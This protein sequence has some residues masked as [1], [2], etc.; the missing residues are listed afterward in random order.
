M[1]SP[2]INDPIA[3]DADGGI[4]GQPLDHAIFH[5]AFWADDEES[6]GLMD[7]IQTSEVDVAAVENVERSGKKDDVVERGDIGGFRV[8]NPHKHGDSDEQVQQHVRFD[9]AFGSLE[10][11]PGKQSQAQVDGGGVQGE[12]RLDLQ[13]MQVRIKRKFLPRLRDHR[14]RGVGEDAVITTLVGLGERAARG[15]VTN[16]KMIATRTDGPQTGDRFPQARAAGELR[17]DHAEQLIHARKQRGASADAM[18]LRRQ[19]KC[20]SRQKIQKLSEDGAAMIH[21]PMIT[22][23]TRRR[24]SKENADLKSCT[25][26]ETQNRSNTPI[27]PNPNRPAKPDS[28][29]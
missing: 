17:E 22:A 27:D 5:F 25:L 6:A 8:G 12:G 11:C 1:L 24:G 29:G 9:P 28:S 26:T 2:Q 13:A 10:A 20:A 16:A 19:F 21:P 7:A 23:L 4:G 18:A 3:C 15:L 14:Q